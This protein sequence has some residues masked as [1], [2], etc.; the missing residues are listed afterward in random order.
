MERQLWRLQDLSVGGA[1][2]F[3]LELYFLALRQL[4]PASASSSR[5]FTTFYIG[6]LEDITSDWKQYKDSPGTQKIIL[7][8]I[9]DIGVRDRGIFSNYPYPDEVTTELVGLLCKMI[10]GQ[11][12]DYIKDA[13]EELRD[14]GF[15]L[16]NDVF[17][18]KAYRAIV[19]SLAAVPPTSFQNA[20]Q[21]IS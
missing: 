14:V 15:R 9:C 4:L 5:D 20:P 16:G 8:L 19:E 21:P 6:A 17:R 7:N 3:T 1:F 2:G 13:M 10:Q 11:E 12:S 18:K